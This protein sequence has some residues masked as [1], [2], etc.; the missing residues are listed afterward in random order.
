MANKKEKAIISSAIFK[1]RVILHETDLQKEDSD[2]IKSVIKELKELV[3][4]EN[5]IKS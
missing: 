5:N 4:D 2:R 3:P 1:L